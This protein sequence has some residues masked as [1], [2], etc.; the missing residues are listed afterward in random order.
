MDIFEVVQPGPLTTVQDL[1]RTG[2]QQYGVPTSGALDDYAFRLGNLLVG[3]D[4]GAA[5]LEITLFGCQLRALRETL[6]AITGAD[7]A[8]TIND[9][10][11][12]AW[13]SLWLKS[14]Q[15]LSFTRLRKGCRAYLAVAGG[16][17]VLEVM[18]SA[19]T[20]VRAGIGGL[21]GRPLRK[22]DVFKAHEGDA[23][24][25]AARIPTRY[26]PAYSHD[27]ALRVILGPQDDYFTDEG[28]S[29]FLNSEYI[30]SA[31]ADRMGYRLEGP[32]IQHRTGADIVSDG[33]PLGAIQVPGDGLPII[34]LADRQTTG[35]YTKIATIISVDI[36]KVAQAK[37][38]DS[39][40]FQQVKGA[41]AIALR[42]KYELQIET[43]KS[44]LRP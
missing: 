35:G 4:E 24:A 32:V 14:G 17:R 40:K 3:N 20:C 5:S 21:N 30:V 27:L 1:G 31:Q 26:I 29:T 43:I 39:I 2:Y 44:F 36:P 9:R 13:E 34:L 15:V 42:Q 38:G 19:S 16:I 12:P 8:P 28:I 18:Q 11:A 33:I 23:S 7:L 22:G 25:K 41:Q 6:I 37:P 10:P